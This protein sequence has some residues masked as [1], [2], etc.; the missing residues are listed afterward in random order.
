MAELAHDGTH[1]RCRRDRDGCGRRAGRRAAAH[2]CAA[3]R[4]PGQRRVRPRHGLAPRASA[5]AGERLE[6][7][8]SR[9]DGRRYPRGGEGRRLNRPARR[10]LVV[11][12][13]LLARRAAAVHAQRAHDAVAVRRQ[14]RGQAVH[15]RGGALHGLRP[16]DDRGPA[17]RCHPHPVLADHRHPVVPPL[18]RRRTPPDPKGS[19]RAGTH[20]LEGA[21]GVAGVR[22]R[23]GGQQL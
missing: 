3:R 15:Q 19:V 8:Q 2:P 20:R 21:Q 22:C 5:G 18:R 10:G 23:Q 16:R 14:R 7:R 1:H 17:L 6:F 11:P 12:G 13:D 4:D 9:R